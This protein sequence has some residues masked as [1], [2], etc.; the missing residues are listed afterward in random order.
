MAMVI[1]VLAAK[2]TKKSAHEII[3]EECARTD[4]HFWTT[5]VISIRLTLNL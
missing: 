5:A 3:V 4:F 2:I 1:V